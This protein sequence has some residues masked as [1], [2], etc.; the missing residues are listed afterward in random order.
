MQGRGAEIRSHSRP[1]R[2]FSGR[3]WGVQPWEAHFPPLCPR[4]H[5]AEFAAMDSFLPGVFRKWH[6]RAGP[7]RSMLSLPS[8]GHHTQPR[9]QDPWG[10][11]NRIL[12]TG[13]Q[14]RD[15]VYSILGLPSTWELTVWALPGLPLCAGS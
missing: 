1:H 4:L 6:P 10:L 14:H 3:V 2:W 9:P 8:P 5:W 12:G 13:Q 15:H 7:P 11:E